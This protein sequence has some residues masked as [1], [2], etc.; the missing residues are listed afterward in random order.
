MTRSVLLLMVF[1]AFSLTAG[2][3]SQTPTTTPAGSTPT[4]ETAK[5]ET[6]LVKGKGGML[7]KKGP[8]DMKPLPPMKF[9]NNN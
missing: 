4:S 1:A 7:I 6:K 5:P 9:K 2:C 8:D 3:D